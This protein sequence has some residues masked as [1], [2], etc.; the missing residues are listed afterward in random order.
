M[1]KIT[2]KSQLFA[3][4]YQQI[5]VSEPQMDACSGLIKLGD[6]IGEEF[7]DLGYLVRYG[8]E[9]WTATFEDIME[10]LSLGVRRVRCSRKLIRFLTCVYCET[11][12]DRKVV[13]SRGIQLMIEILEYEDAYFRTKKVEG[14]DH[15]I[16]TRHFK[17]KF[18]FSVCVRHPLRQAEY[19]KEPCADA[20]VWRQAEH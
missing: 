17:R 1:E 12:M 11:A 5:V 20:E 13:L 8:W 14:R 10:T 15:L 4:L 7:L 19:A 2:E 18:G 16:S 3:W 9:G 6:V